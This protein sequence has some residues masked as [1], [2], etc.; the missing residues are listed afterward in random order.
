MTLKKTPIE[1]WIKGKIGL[2]SQEGLTREAL[3]DYQMDRL[4]KTLGYV[5]E[6]SP[7]Y[8]QRL[9]A[10]SSGGIHK[11]EDLSDWPLT[12]AD[13]IR[14]DPLQFLCVSQGEVSRAVTLPSDEPTDG[15]KR[16]FFTEGDLELTVDFFHHGMSTLVAPGQ[17]VLILMP[18]Y[19]PDSVGDLLARGLARLN[20][21]SYLHG[22]VRDPAETIAAIIDLNIDCLVGIPVQV[23]GLVRH[24][25]AGDIPRERL[26]GLVLST[27]YVARSIVSEISRLWGCPVYPHYGT[28]E[29]GYGG[30]VACA[31]LNGYHLREADLLFEIVDPDSGRPLPPGEAGEVIFTTLTRKA[32]PLI[33]FRTGDLAAFIPEPCP[34]GSAIRRLGQVRSGRENPIPLKSALKLSTVDLDETIFTI[35]AVL[36]YRAEI[37][38]REGR[39]YLRLV[40]VTTAENTARVVNDVK[41]A[42]GR[43]DSV[44]TALSQGPLEIEVDCQD[45]DEW[46]STGVAK[47]K[48]IDLRRTT[49]YPE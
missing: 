43:L 12:T 6:C 38:G 8:R 15:P 17:R 5:Q 42:I 14:K 25:R 10:R 21:Q 19:Q 27:D 32:M 41:E 3:K 11:P 22:P 47:R 35:P 44:R 2:E 28:T 20:V 4:R 45:H 40:L 9:V 39:E 18:G 29:M 16:I 24:P 34:C 31:A 46:L 36:N 26:K 33:R 1:N 49:N 13:D 23:L 37:H 30:G 48:I 7:F